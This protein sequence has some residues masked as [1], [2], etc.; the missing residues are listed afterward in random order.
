MNN[1]F[2]V[3]I[4]ED[5]KNISNFI[6]KILTSHGYRVI[7]SL[8][9]KE[10]MYLIAS[11]CPDIILLDLGL[12]DMDGVDIIRQ[13]RQWSSNPIIVVS[14]RI[15]ENDKVQALDAGADD[16]ITKPFGTS[17]LLARI[18]TSI[19]HNN[20]LNKE[21]PLFKYPYKAMDLYIDFLNHVITLKGEVIHLTPV[22]Y[23]IVAYLALN[24]GKVMTH[25]SIMKEVWG[26]Y[27][28]EDN[29]ILRVN[30][31]NIRRKIEINPAEPKY[32][33]T[34]VGVGYRMLDDELS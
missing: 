6:S 34:E 17:E 9:G 31:A 18:R 29:K 3:L 5:E 26:P 33:F 27:V 2:S 20:K 7:T 30:M 23:K 11:Q 16:Y 24:S 19:R 21:A 14:A 25:S 32:I 4:I 1:N 22:E 28:E 10:G 8:S 15:Q 12:P 13:V